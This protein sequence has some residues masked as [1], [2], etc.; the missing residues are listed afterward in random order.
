MSQCQTMK[1]ST[2]VEQNKGSF[3]DFVDRLFAKIR[4]PE[5]FYKVSTIPQSGKTIWNLDLDGK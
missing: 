4:Y 2:A 5:S 1:A 3:E